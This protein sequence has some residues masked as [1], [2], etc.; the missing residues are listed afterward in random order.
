MTIVVVPFR[1][2]DPKRRLEAAAGDR[3]RLAAAMLADVLDAALA[4]GR[5]VVVAGTSPSLPAGVELVP[6]P[7]RGQGAAVRSALDAAA[8]AGDP[9]EAGMFLVVNAD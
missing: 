7:G 1:D 4:V 9:V 3:R 2:S 8:A 5:A 6:D